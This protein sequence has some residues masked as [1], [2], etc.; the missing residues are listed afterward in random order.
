[1]GA[2][3]AWAG[4]AVVYIVECVASGQC[5]RD[6]FAILRASVFRANQEPPMNAHLSSHTH[7]GAGTGPAMNS[8]EE[9]L[10]RLRRRKPATALERDFYTSPEDYRIDLDMIWYRDWLFV[11]HDCEV[12]NTGNY[13]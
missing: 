7:S 13:L 2:I 11:G 5:R 8:R 10:S 4:G 6:D 12:P 1:M 3:L 9:M